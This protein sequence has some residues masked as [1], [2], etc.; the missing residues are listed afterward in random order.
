MVAGRSLRGIAFPVLF[1]KDVDKRA[2]KG[3]TASGAY[4]DAHP[5]VAICP[6]DMRDFKT[7]EE[8]ESKCTHVANEIDGDDEE[9]HITFDFKARDEAF[10][11]YGLET[12]V[13]N[14]Q[15]E[16]LQEKPDGG[17]QGYFVE[18]GS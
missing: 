1:Y 3:D 5:V 16:T 2:D 17:G 14:V 13:G 8:Q 15:A 6:G 4:I 12:Q 11:E 10:K 18:V 7:E 9:A